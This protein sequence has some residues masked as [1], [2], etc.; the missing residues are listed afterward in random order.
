[1][2]PLQDTIPHRESPFVTWALIGLNVGVFLL[3]LALPE[4]ALEALIR[5]FGVVPAR[6]TEPGWMENPANYWPLLTN[7]FLHGGWMHIIGNMWTLWIFGDNVEDRLGHGRYLVFYLLCGLAASG[8]HI[9]LHPDSTIPA[10]GAS[11]AISGVM[12]AYFLLFPH[13]RIIAVFPV[14]FIPYFLELPAVV[15]LGAWFLTQLFSGTFSILAPGTGGGIAWWAHIG[16]FLAGALLVRPMHRRRWRVY[17]PY[18][19]DEEI[20]IRYLYPR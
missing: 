16:G 7:M 11:G 9:L 14:F 17:R 10:I 18:F 12:G 19:A 2:F 3:E 13:S 20:P 1:M 15:Y 5:T 4:P 6:Y 8:T